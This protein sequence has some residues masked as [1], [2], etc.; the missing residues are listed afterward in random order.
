[1]LP[2]YP[3]LWVYLL[4][5]SGGTP[6]PCVCVWTYLRSQ[7]CCYG[8]R[9]YHASSTAKRKTKRQGQNGHCACVWTGLQMVGHIYHTTIVP[10][11]LSCIS[12]FIHG[13]N[14]GKTPL[15]MRVDGFADGGTR[16]SHHNRDKTAI[17]YI[18]LRSMQKQGQNAIAHACGRVCRW[19]DTYITPQSCQD[20]Y[21]VYYASSAAKTKTK[22]HCACVWT[23]LQMVGTHISHHNRAKTA[24]VYI[25]LRSMQKQG[26]NA[27]A[28]ACGWICRWWDTYITPQSCQDCYR[29]YHA[30]FNAKTR[31]KRHCA[32]VWTGLQMVGH[33]YRTTI[34]LIVLSC[35]LRFIRGKK[36]KTK[37]HCACVWT[38][39]QMVGH[40]RAKTAIVYITLRSM[41]KQGQNAIAH[42]CGRVCRW[43]DTY[44]EPQSC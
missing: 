43:W 13:K 39:L 38:G 22:R 19:W 23:G 26:Q 7:W 16:I 10:R 3:W 24:I 42:A 41:Q 20:C 25:T 5:T 40:N 2:G 6:Y 14:K 34:M 32:C 17:V 11:L 35:I 15:R 4:Q 21:R 8:P 33:V 12:R 37:R 9:V 31:A 1:M 30:S 28:H 44:I 29:V 18:T 36:T 27:I